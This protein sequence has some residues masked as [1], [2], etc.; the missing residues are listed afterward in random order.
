MIFCHNRKESAKSKIFDFFPFGRI[1]KQNLYFYFNPIDNVEIIKLNGYFVSPTMLQSVA[2][3]SL[4]VSH[5]S[6]KIEN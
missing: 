2:W 3:L 5:A 6:Q 4:S 1:L